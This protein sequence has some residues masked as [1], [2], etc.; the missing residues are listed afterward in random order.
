MEGSRAD[1]DYVPIQPADC[2]NF[3]ISYSSK[4]AFQPRFS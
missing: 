4:R 3:R 1:G 2:K